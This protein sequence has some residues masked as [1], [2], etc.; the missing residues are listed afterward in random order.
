MY[1]LS[2]CI[3]FRTG[4]ICNLH[5]TVHAHCSHNNHFSISV[6]F[7]SDVAPHFLS[8]HDSPRN[9]TKSRVPGHP[10]RNCAGSSNNLVPRGTKVSAIDVTQKVFFECLYWFQDWANLASSQLSVCSYTPTVHS[11][12]IS[13]FP[14]NF[15]R[16]WPLI[17]CQHKIHQVI[18][19]SPGTLAESR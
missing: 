17:F 2:V 1:S 13:R 5:Q 6:Q 4:P 16:M 18:W 8:A 19:P 10:I 14:Y 15:F 12:T 7:F 9:L 11:T 3:G